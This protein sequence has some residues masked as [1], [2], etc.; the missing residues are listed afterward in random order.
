MN[1]AFALFDKNEHSV[2]IQCPKCYNTENDKDSIVETMF[3]SDDD[4]CVDTRAGIEGIEA[5]V[6]L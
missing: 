6:I 2:H 3:L 1:V 4:C 5:R